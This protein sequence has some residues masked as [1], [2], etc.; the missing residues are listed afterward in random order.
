MSRW[1]HRYLMN[2]REQRRVNKNSKRSRAQLHP[3]DWV[4]VTSTV[5]K[6]VYFFVLLNEHHSIHSVYSL[7][8]INH[9]NASQITFFIHH[10]SSPPQISVVGL[11]FTY[12]SIFSTWCTRSICA[13]SAGY[14][15]KQLGRSR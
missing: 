2:K 10:V 4:H 15:S 1:C 14:P 12:L 7:S 9:K 13:R 6:G 11:C 5:H 3:D 8:S